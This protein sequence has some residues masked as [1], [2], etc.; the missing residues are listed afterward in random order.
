M[1]LFRIHIAI[2][3]GGNCISA[4]ERWEQVA[5]PILVAVLESLVAGRELYSRP[6]KPVKN[7]LFCTT[8]CPKLLLTQVSQLGN[9][10]KNK[11]N[12]LE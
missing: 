2:H 9:Q 12:K 3:Q 11:G 1:L 7:L 5:I 6:D 8:H 10:F 4:H